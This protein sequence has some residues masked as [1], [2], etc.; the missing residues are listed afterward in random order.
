[1]HCNDPFGA[2]ALRDGSAL[3]RELWVRAWGPEYPVDV[4]PHSSCTWRLLQQLVEA[5]GMKPG[6]SLV[7][8]GCG[9]GGVG[10]WLARELELH[11]V[12][13]DRSST[14]IDVARRRA[15]ESGASAVFATGDFAATGL[16]DGTMDAAVSIDAL[17]F[18]QDVE[19][20]L[21][22]SRRI[23][24]VGGRL[25][26]TT[27]ELS[28]TNP[29]REKLG[30]AWEVALQRHGFDVQQITGRPEVSSLW[31]S[32]YAEWRAHE[33]ALRRELPSERVDELI[34]EAR[35]LGPR[36]DEERAW[37]LVA[38]VKRL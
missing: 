15:A 1:M 35:Q 34:A 25:A 2:A 23:L 6:D 20:A 12:G 14:A 9:T 17:P 10:L 24:R 31:R 38:A 36:L 3:F 33:P 37:L 8:L 4:R 29:A 19:A 16:P 13:V 32:I 7:D 22:E 27:R 28:S 18:A 21:L 5:L 11:L 30:A 26:F